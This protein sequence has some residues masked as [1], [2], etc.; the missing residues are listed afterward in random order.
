[1]KQMNRTSNMLAESEK[2][3]G[4]LEANTDAIPQRD[5]IFISHATPG[6]NTFAIWLASRLSM[7]G[8]QV[9]CDQER[10]IGGEDFWQD[11]EDALRQQAIKFVLVVSQ[12]AFDEKGRVRDGIK[13]EIALANILRKELGDEGFII[14]MRIDDTP[15]KDF[16]TDFIR[17]NAISCR[18][19]WASGLANLIE[20]LERDNVVRQEHFTRLSLSNW[21]NVHKHHTCALIKESE[22]IQSNWL[23]ILKLPEFI[24]FFE[25]SSVRGVSGVRSI[26]SE[27]SV[28]CSDHFRL[29]LSFA[30]QYQLQDALGDKTLI[31]LRG[32]L[33]TKDFL[34]GKMGDIPSIAPRDAKNKVTSLVRQAFDGLMRERGLESYEMANGKLAWWFP[35][36]VPEDGQLHYVDFGKNKRKRA[37]RGVYKN[38][39]GPD[40]VKT[41]RYYW[42]LGF[43]GKPFI[44]EE[45]F[46]ALQPRIIISEDGKTPL[47]NKKRLNSVRRSLTK[48]WFNE[49]WRTLVLGF[50]SWL[51]NGEDA[52]NLPTGSHEPIRVGGRPLCFESPLAIASDR[53]SDNL[54]DKIGD[55]MEKSE[56]DMRLVDPA[57]IKLEQEEEA[58]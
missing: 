51:A 56:H 2:A 27:C 31:N 15:H 13:N 33:R 40:G 43:T 5:T 20:V 28:P 48:M 38:Q 52:L 53:I 50:S 1:M 46:I 14:P 3:G 10:L 58:E 9:W 11:I 41:P 32:T 37:V 44:T 12:N 49:K 29:L 34:F 19:N 26:A 21:R 23:P 47:Q 36:G 42:H 18:E 4:K 35:E 45:P 25:C 54:T 6:D 22:T 55:E 17:L 39:E 57:F 16:S 24:N 8:Y 7:A 30:E